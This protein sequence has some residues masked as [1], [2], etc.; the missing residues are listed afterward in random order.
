M[1]RALPYKEEGQEY[2]AVLTML[3][4]GRLKALCVDGMER[5]AHIRGKMRKKVWIGT[6]DIILVS[7]REY[8]EDR[9]DVIM[10]YTAD[11]ARQLRREGEIPKSMEERIQFAE[12]KKDVEAAKSKNVYEE[13]DEMSEDEDSDSEDDD[14]EDSDSEDDES[15]EEEKKVEKKPVK[16]VEDMEIARAKAK[17]RA[18]ELEVDAK[19]KSLPQGSREKGRMMKQKRSSDRD[20]KSSLFEEA[21]M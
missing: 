17:A 10:K 14:D 12:A 2:A 4:N 13:L 20:K 1:K 18:R 21:F 9:C 7:L 19:I 5:M 6:G 11:E 8:Q 15:E 3:G 16:V